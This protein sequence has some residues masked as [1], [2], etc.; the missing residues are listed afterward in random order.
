M[1]ELEFDCLFFSFGTSHGYKKSP[2]HIPEKEGDGTR[3]K[4]RE[5]M[6]KAV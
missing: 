5:D 6:K 2:T 1:T 3:E 4:E